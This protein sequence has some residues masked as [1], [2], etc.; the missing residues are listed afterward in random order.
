M[1]IAEILCLAVMSVGMPRAEVA[2][3]YMETIAQ[4][5]E[6]NSVRPEL[7]IAVIYHESR[8]SPKAVS[9]SKACGL[10]QVMP[11][12]TGNKKTGVEKL[13]CR[14]L[15]DGHV[16]IQAGTKTLAFWMHKKYARIRS[17]K[18]NERRS[19]CSYFAGYQCAG[20]HPNA[21]GMRYSRKVRR[22]ANKIKRAIESVKE[23]DA[24]YR[25]DEVEYEEV[26]CGC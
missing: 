13:T 9:P 22:T 1:T 2:C 24:L 23:C 25:T 19:L 4:E 7:V 6:A 18:K 5:A 21:A 17:S 8:W 15:F 16:N 20:R 10:M 14:Q 26:G 3:D 11:K 12:F